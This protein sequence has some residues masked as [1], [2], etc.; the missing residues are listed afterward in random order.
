MSKIRHLRP[1]GGGP[2]ICGSTARVVYTT[3]TPA[4]ADCKRCRKIAGLDQ[5]D[6]MAGLAGI[7]KVAHKNDTIETESN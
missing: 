5:Y 6:P 2:P 7:L 3:A 1:A 4:A